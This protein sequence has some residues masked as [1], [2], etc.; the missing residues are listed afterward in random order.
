MYE[1]RGQPPI[2]F[3]VF[4]RRLARHG[5]IAAALLAVSLLLG[6]IGYHLLEKLSWIDAF[7]NSTMLLGGMGP[8]DPPKTFSGKL[9]AGCY[10]L[11]AGLI[12]IVAA[13]LLGAPVFHRILHRFHWEEEERRRRG[14][15]TDQG[16][17]AKRTTKIE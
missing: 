4:L 2:P 15:K 17:A 13:S 10:A 6:M 7:L 5:G 3:R 11:Y 12:F 8:V 14:A 9:F 16:K 1:H